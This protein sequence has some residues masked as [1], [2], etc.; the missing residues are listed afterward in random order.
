MPPGLARVAVAAVGSVAIAAGAVAA[1]NG[2]L[3]AIAVAVAGAALVAW[4]VF[5]R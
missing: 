2:V 5:P 3:A 1:L 4:S